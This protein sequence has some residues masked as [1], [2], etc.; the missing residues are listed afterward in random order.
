MSIDDRHLFRTNISEQPVGTDA[1]VK[2]E[3]T[4]SFI[5]ENVG[6]QPV[7]T[8][9][10][11]VPSAVHIETTGATQDEIERDALILDLA[12]RL[13]EELKIRNHPPETL[14][15]AI[16]CRLPLVF[17]VVNDI[18]LKEEPLSPQEEHAVS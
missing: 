3:K 9:A 6:E 2:P 17:S 14:R 16:K 18:L 5:H 1:V 11:F 12:G 8:G 7:L 4:G 13:I 10:E 15:R